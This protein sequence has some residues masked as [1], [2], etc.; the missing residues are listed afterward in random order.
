MYGPRNVSGPIP[1]FWRRLT[2]GEPC[3]VVNTARD[4]VYIDDLVDAVTT[5]IDRECFGRFDICSGEHLPIERLYRTVADE[6]GIDTEPGRAAAGS[7]DVKQMQLDGTL[8]A[9]R[10][11][12]KPRVP[13]AEGVARA[14]AWYAAEGVTA[15]FS[16][17]SLPAA[18][19]KG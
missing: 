12:W 16:H 4:M 7:D 8:A 11:D 3:T 17:L 5:A 6:L 10:L 19:L 13:L 1:T 14:A 15:T 2:A 18:S 9:T